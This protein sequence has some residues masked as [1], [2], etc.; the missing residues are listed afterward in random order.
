MSLRPRWVGGGTLG[1]MTTGNVWMRMVLTF[2]G[3]A[4][5]CMAVIGIRHLRV[6]GHLGCSLTGMPGVFQSVNPRAQGD[7]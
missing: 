5:R 4:G 6:T 3:A 1:K 2:F 7:V